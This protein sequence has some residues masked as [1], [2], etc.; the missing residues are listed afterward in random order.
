MIG[1]KVKAIAWH[2]GE[3]GTVIKHE[4]LSHTLTDTLVRHDSGRECWYASRDL[5]PIDGGEPLPDR[6]EIKRAADLKAAEQLRAIFGRK[7]GS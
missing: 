5:L 6:M 3:S 4:P 2:G 1:R 7:N